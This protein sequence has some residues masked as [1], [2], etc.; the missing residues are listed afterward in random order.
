MQRLRFLSFWLVVA[1]LT[2]AVSPAPAQVASGSLA[3]QVLDQSGAAVPGA[4][5]ALINEQTGIERT[6][7]SDES[8]GFVFPVVP[9]GIY[10]V[11]TEHAGFRTY[12]VKG[13]QVEIAQ[14]V[15]H[16]ILMELGETATT[17]EVSATAPLLNQRS[18]ELSQAIGHRQIVEIPLNGRNFMD[19]TKLVP[20]V[21]EL[22]GTS[23]ST[24]LAING[25]R[26]NQVGFYFDGIDTRTEERGKPA[27]S[28][29]IEAIEEFRIQQNAFSAEYGR[30]P[31]AINLTLRP[32]TNDIHGT[33]FEF[34]R[35]NALDARS[36]FSPTVDPLRR[37]QFGGVVSG[38][39]LRNKTFFMANYE[40]LR[41]RRAATLF[42]SVPTLKQRQGDFSDDDP[43]FDPASYSP[44]ANTRQQFAGNRIPRERFS[45]IG[46]AA[47]T[48]FPEPNTPAAGGFNYIVRTA[49]TDDSDQFHGRLDH[50]INERSLLFGRYSFSDSI[51]EIPSGLPLTGSTDTTRVHSV[52]VQESHTFSPNKVNQFR[53]GWTFYDTTL[54]FPTAD[55][56]PAVTEFGLFNLNPPAF[57]AGIPRIETIGLSNIGASPFQPQGP[58]EHI[59]SLADDFSWIAGKHTIKFGFDGRY[60]RPAG[61]V[62]VTPNGILTFQNRYTTQPGVARTGSAVADMLLGAVF[63][64]RATALAESNGLVSLKYFYTGY[65]IQDEIRLARNFTLNLG[66]RYEYQTPYKERYNDLAIFDPLT[67]RFLEVD[68]DIDDLHEPD[69]NNFAPRIG[70]AW[71]AA[72]KTV[73]RAGGGVFYGQ[74]RGSEFTS[75]QLSPPF[76][77]DSTLNASPNIPDLEG[78]LFPAPQVRD[79][80]GNILVLPTTNIFTLDPKFRTNYTYQWNVGVQREIAG[81]VM[82]EVA[83]VGNSAHK[84]TARDTVNQA[85]LD[86]DPSRPTPVQSRRPNPNVADVSVVK[87]LDNSNY[88]G[89]NVKLDK[90]FSH[91]LS[92]LGSYTWSKA[93]GIGGALFGDQS[94]TQDARDRRAEYGPLEFN[95]TQRLTVAWI[96]EL[97]F[98]PQ[99]RLASDARGVAGAIVGGWSFQGTF[100]AHTGFPLTPRS[101]VSSNVGRQDQNRADRL[102]DGNLSGSTRT[103]DRWFDTSCF[104]NHPFGRFGNSGAGVIVGPGLQTFD[105]TLMKN[106]RLSIGAAREPLNV[107][108][109]AEAFNA[110]NHPVF[111]DPNM[112]AGTAQFGVI[113]STRVGGRQLQLALKLLF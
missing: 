57:A 74:P 78:R 86:P 41:T 99:R 63:S 56:N 94:N 85:F 54:T 5:L 108:F 106:T 103:I 45:Q 109:R 35:N 51:A 17:V 48:Y 22:A 98:G 65:Y 93:M 6:T 90:R 43:I 28:P 75:F 83:Y 44:Q 19:L 26:A 23:Q 36:F 59:Y 112:N 31:A 69:R 14:N 46:T 68:K 37:N 7:L 111:G 8:G 27:F 89:L 24:G 2:T 73:I 25:Q 18:A 16:D 101:T 100:R 47:L 104:V 72:P 30:T 9:S 12:A 32:G 102:C 81:N 107:Q 3:G 21:T 20:G 62:Q 64:G 49:N 4:R 105:L 60:Y 61:K 91:G 55:G 67:A 11:R 33:L 97:P 77:V 88:H 66:L 95:Q 15:R 13:L 76:V 50:Q 84:L 29:S 53:I 39:I 34:L 1:F 38:P 42:H 58:R 82:L 70:L 92:V 110:F 87:S 40:G 79:A 10:T 96:Y 71:T 52:T 113:R 80:G